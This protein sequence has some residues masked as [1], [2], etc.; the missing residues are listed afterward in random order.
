MFKKSK[1]NQL[2]FGVGNKS[3]LYVLR[4]NNIK[5]KACT[6]RHAPP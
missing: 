5:L 2:T 4:R 6:S 1:A 3:I